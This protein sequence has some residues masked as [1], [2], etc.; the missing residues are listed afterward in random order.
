MALFL[1]LG[2]FEAQV[3]LDCVQIADFGFQFGEVTNGLQFVGR[4]LMIVVRT[5]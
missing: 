3:V 2:K 4:I 1:S 5:S